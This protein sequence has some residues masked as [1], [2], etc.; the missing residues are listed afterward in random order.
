M[1]RQVFSGHGFRND[2]HGG[3]PRVRRGSLDAYIAGVRFYAETY[4]VSR[5]LRTPCPPRFRTWG[6]STSGSLRGR[7][8]RRRS[9]SEPPPH[10]RTPRNVRDRRRRA[11][12]K[13]PSGALKTTSPSA[14]RPKDGGALRRLS[15]WRDASFIQLSKNRTRQSAQGSVSMSGEGDRPQSTREKTFWRQN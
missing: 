13:R 1:Q 7:R 8:A 2:C 6:V 9:S 12:S 10:A 14:R 4:R 15:L 5:G 11:T 3:T